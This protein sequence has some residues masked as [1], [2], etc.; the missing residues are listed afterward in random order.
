MSQSEFSDEHNEECLL[1]ELVADQIKSEQ[2]SGN[3]MK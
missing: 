2:S 1:E 3:Q